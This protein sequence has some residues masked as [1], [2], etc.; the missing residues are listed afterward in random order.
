MARLGHRV[1][2]VRGPQAAG[3]APAN[4]AQAA[5]ATPGRAVVVEFSSGQVD[6]VGEAPGRAVSSDGASAPARMGGPDLSQA[7]ESSMVDQIA[8]VVRANAART[9]RQIVVRLNP[10]ELGRVRLM[11]HSD[12]SD[13]RGVLKVESPETLAELQRE[14]GALVQRLAESGVQLRRLDVDLADDGSQ[15]SDSGGSLARGGQ[16]QTHDGPA[17]MGQ[18][19]TPDSTGEGDASEAD[20]APTMPNAYHVDDESINVWI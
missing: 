10:P 2:S 20:A 9:G 15:G 3:E 7:P 19:T 17:D 16:G 14:A 4:V 5:S 13:V 1:G 8:R 18:Q 11:L 12:G 6:E